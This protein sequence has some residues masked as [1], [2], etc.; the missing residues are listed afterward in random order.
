MHIYLLIIICSLSWSVPESGDNKNQGEGT[1]TEKNIN[2]LNSKYY[3]KRD[4]AE[5]YLVKEGDRIIQPCFEGFNEASDQG[6]A[7][8]LDLLSPMI[9]DDRYNGLAWSTAEADDIVLRHAAIEYL[10]AHPEK[11]GQKFLDWTRDILLNGRCTEKEAYLRGIRKPAPRAQIRIFGDHVGLLNRSHASMAIEGIGRGWQRDACAILNQLIVDLYGGIGDRSLLLEA[12][13]RLD[14]VATVE[15]TESMLAGLLTASPDLRGEAYK[16][17]QTINS[18]L[19]RDHRY[20]E[21]VSFQEKIYHAAPAPW[22]H[23]LDFV[24]SGIQYLPNPAK[25]APVLDLLARKHEGR[26]GTDARIC[27]IEIEMARALMDFWAGLG[28]ASERLAS[29]PEPWP[30]N[31]ASGKNEYALQRVLSKKDFLYGALLVLEGGDPSTAFNR[32]LN[33][34]PYDPYRTEIDTILTGRF[35]ITSLIWRLN[36]YGLETSSKEVY[37]ALLQTLQQDEPGCAYFPSPEESR[38]SSDRIRSQLPINEAYFLYHRCGE[39]ETASSKLDYFIKTI[40]DSSLNA[41]RDL[42]ARAYFYKGLAM[43]DLGQSDEA[44]S[45]IERGIKIY[46]ELEAGLKD[47]W[48]G[49]GKDAAIEY[50][51]KEKARGMLNAGSIAHYYLKDAEKSAEFT[52]KAAKASPDFNAILI[53]KAIVQARK[54][55]FILAREVIENMIPFPDRYYNFACLCGMM[56]DQEAAVTYLGKHFDEYVPPLRTR[57]ESAYARQDPDLVPLK[58]NPEF[59]RLVNAKD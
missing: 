56:G 34:A 23:A 5:S 48:P 26:R 51:K 12:M 37:K 11:N 21:I 2:H 57:L 33:I 59:I 38:Y 7:L 17:A 27:L 8:R 58:N 32:A 25:T 20:E 47:Y 36:Q 55:E 14:D 16:L 30:E 29:S 41:N 19:Y 31:D 52:R 4:K 22:E 44:L 24:N 13:K 50:Y 10:S 53:A 1:K 43:A 45:F 42:L 46:E 35:S 18:H 6:K 3:I 9:P 40:R 54:K 28:N 15:A 39:P 49:T